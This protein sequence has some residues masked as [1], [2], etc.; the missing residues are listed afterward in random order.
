MILA[1]FKCVPHEEDKSAEDRKH[2][3]RPKH[4]E[5]RI[6]GIGPPRLVAM[7]VLATSSVK[8]NWLTAMTA[9][10]IVHG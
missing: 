10:F 5:S 3:D 7:T 4:L 8:G 6:A 9:R 2:Q 1:R